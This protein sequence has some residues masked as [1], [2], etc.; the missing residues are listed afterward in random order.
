MSEGELK[1]TTVIK[2]CIAWLIFFIIVI[3]FMFII[4]LLISLIIAI[5]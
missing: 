5:P 4:G 3:V 2:N 1:A